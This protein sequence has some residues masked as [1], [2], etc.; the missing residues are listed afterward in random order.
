MS[1]LFCLLSFFSISDATLS[2]S[3]NP[4]DSVR[5]PGHRPLPVVRPVAKVLDDYAHLSFVVVENPGRKD[6][7]SAWTPDKKNPA[8]CAVNDNSGGSA[9]VRIPKV[10]GDYF[11]DL[12]VWNDI[13]SVRFRTYVTRKGNTLHAFDLDNEY[14]TWI[15]DA[16]IYQITP[17]AFIRGG[18]YDDIAA[19]LPEIRTLGVNTLY[20][21][22]VYKTQR[23][24]QG[25][26]IIDYFS[27]RPDLGSEEQLRSLITR[28]RDLGMRVIFD[29]VPN[30]TSIEHPYAQ[31]VMNDRE[32]SPYYDYYQRTF[33]GAPYG[34]HYTKS[35]A[36]FVHYF[37]RDLINLNFD[38][39]DVQRWIIDACKFWVRKFD[40]DGY[41]FDAVWAVNARNPTFG[42]R[43]RSELKSIKPDILLLAEDKPLPSTFRSGFDVAYDWTADTS[44]VSQWSWQTDFHERESKTVFNF[45]NE[46]RRAEL[47]RAALFGNGCVDVP[48]LRF[49]ENNDLPRFGVHHSEAQTLM[50]AAL[51]FS[52]PG[53]P[54]LYNGQEVGVEAHPYTRHSVFSREKDIYSVMPARFEFYR[55]LITLRSAHSALRTGRTEEVAVVAEGPVLGFRRWDDREQFLILV[56]LGS[57]AVTAIQPVRSRRKYK[58]VLTGQKFQLSEVPLEPYSVRW[59]FFK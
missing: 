40:L 11:F 51:L 15:D 38:N 2:V 33:D 25:Y 13:D 6:L 53:I 4:V 16:I 22:P 35:E 59:L 10:E 39:E 44:W 7:H 42:N 8:T 30:H 32:G 17:N 12:L 50:A 27:L 41:R 37:W 49:I 45:P 3:V 31:S 58:D 19:K 18:T 46:S 55:K 43:L 52:L 29:F 56:N 26:D 14:A 57:Q 21:Q 36:G 28:A 47:L 23:G 20:L 54:M 5:R 1:F 9:S 34:S 24:G 48:C